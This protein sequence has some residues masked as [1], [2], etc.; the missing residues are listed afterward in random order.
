MHFD[1][2]YEFS[3]PAH[4]GLGEQASLEQLIEDLVLAEACGF[5]TAWLAEHHFMPQYSHSSAPDL[6][7][8]AASQRTRTLRLGHAIVPLPYHHPVQ[9][10]ERAAMLDLLS[11]GRLEFGFG[12][13]FSPREY[14]VFGVSM[15]SS[16]TRVLESVQIL[17]QAFSGEAIHFSGMHFD[18]QDLQCLPH[19]LQRPHPPL[20]MAAVSP[21][22]FELAAELGVGVLVGPFKPW[23]MARADIRRYR[24][25][26]R[27]YHGSDAGGRV[28]M[29]LG[30]VCL[31]DHA[32]ARAAAQAALPWF[33]GALF[34]QTA[35]VLRK[36]YDS[37]EYYRRLGRLDFLLG[38]PPSLRLLEQLGMAVAGDPIHCIKQLRRYQEAGVD[39]L[40]C[41]VGAGASPSV[42]VQQ[43]LRTLGTQVLPCFVAPTTTQTTQPAHSGTHPL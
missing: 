14:E 17:R 1:L 18:I 23:F 22:S 8:A 10:A 34:Q 3:V 15:A 16:R 13:G 20:W 6:I 39:H 12:R 31:E 28:A 26:W 25:A 7:L 19:C 27:R 41:A 21:D 35:P 42:V 36:L 9:V 29:T 11:G 37:Y 24:E 5:R 4:L 40:L 33:Y 30:I 38:R 32:T 2:F 43:S